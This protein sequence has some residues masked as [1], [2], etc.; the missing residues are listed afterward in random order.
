ML[1][2]N[3]LSINSGHL[4]FVDDVRDKQ[5]SIMVTLLFFSRQKK[6]FGRH[7]TQSEEL[8]LHEILSDSTRRESKIPSA[9]VTFT[10]CHKL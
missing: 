6:I 9:P 7:A 10:E 4:L 5:W 8:L 1:K 3:P 2:A